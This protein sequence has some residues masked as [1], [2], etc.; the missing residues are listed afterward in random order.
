MNARAQ[1]RR[2]RLL[3]LLSGGLPTR[4]A[5]KQSKAGE[6]NSNNKGTDGFGETGKKYTKTWL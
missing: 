2:R 1:R 6:L 4:G 5:G 3:L